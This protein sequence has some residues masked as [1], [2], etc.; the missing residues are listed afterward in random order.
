[1]A[2]YGPPRAGGVFRVVAE[3]RMRNN[4]FGPKPTNRDFGAGQGSG[5]YVGEGL[6]NQPYNQG[7][8][9]RQSIGQGVY[10]GGAKARSLGPARQ[11]ILNA[12]G[13][14]RIERT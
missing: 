5:R 14:R 12:S 4:T 13:Q 3:N 2:E 11:R 9:D 8:R 1:M 10:R 7:G 6:R